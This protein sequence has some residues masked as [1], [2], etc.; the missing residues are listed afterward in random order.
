MTL[1][2]LPEDSP[3]LADLVDPSLRRS[4]AIRVNQAIL[5]ADKLP[6]EARVRGLVHLRAYAENE[7]FDGKE[8][9][10]KEFPKLDLGIADH[11]RMAL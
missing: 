8:S 5:E 10:R 11:G 9:Q 2:C 1:I 6:T 3:Q 7:L 4:I